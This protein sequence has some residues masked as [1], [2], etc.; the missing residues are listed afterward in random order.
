MGPELDFDAA[1]AESTDPPLPF[2]DASFELIRADASFT[3]LTEGWAE[4]L[5]ELRRLLTGDGILVVGLAPRESFESLTGHPWDDDRIGMTVLSALNGPGAR[6][7][8]HSDWWLR[9]HWGRAFEVVSIDEADGRRFVSL[10][11]AEGEA[12]ADQ[13]ERAEPGEQRELAAARANASDLVGQLDRAARRWEQEREDTDRE[14]MRRAF[15]EADHDWARSG[16]GSP[17]ML[18]AAEYESTTSWRITKPMRA[19]GRML[20][21][22]R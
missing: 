19:V 4:W 10:R 15:V 22:L 12:S 17:A 20:R 7:A 9:A 2:A 13:I 21:R 6:I 5:L 16:P 18:I 11:R 14:L 1:L 3:R 8:F